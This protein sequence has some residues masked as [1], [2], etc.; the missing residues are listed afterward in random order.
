ML[1]GLMTR[2]EKLTSSEDRLVGAEKLVQAKRTG[3][4]VEAV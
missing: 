4:N 2:L 3:R 1:L